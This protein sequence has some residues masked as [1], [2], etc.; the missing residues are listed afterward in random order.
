MVVSRPELYLD[1]LSDWLATVTGKRI[2]VS[3]VSNYW[4][5]LGFTRRKLSILAYER[6]NYLRAEFTRL[7]GQFRPEQLIF[8]DESS[9]DN[10]NANRY[11]DICQ[12][13]RDIIQ[14]LEILYVSIG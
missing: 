2:T 5:R 8:I 10:R 4:L 13:A 11:L 1:E 12:R 3:A 6:D 7:I 9:K 14:A